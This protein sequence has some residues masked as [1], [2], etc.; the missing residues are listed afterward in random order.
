[1]RIQEKISQYEW[2]AV[3]LEGLQSELQPFLGQELSLPRE[4]GGWWHQYVCPKHHTELLFDPLENDAHAFYCTHG[5]EWSG[6]PYRGAWLVFKHQS[7]VRYALQSATVYAAAHDR[8]YAEL[9]KSILVRYAAQFPLYPVHPDAQPWMLSGRAFHQALT[10][11][12]WA[13]SL[14]RG[15]LL[16]CDEGIEFSSADQKVLDTFFHMLE[17]SMLQ[18][19]RVLVHE[20]KNPENNYTA[21][22]NAALSCICAV[23]GDKEKLLELV[24]GEGGL[25]H[26]LT[27]GIKPD[28]FEFEGTLYY[29]IFVLRAYLITA[30]MADRFAVDLYAVQGDQG[31][32][33]KGMF[34]VLVELANDQGELPALHDGPYKRLPFAREISEV[35]EIGLSKYKES[36]YL[37]LLANAYRQLNGEASRT[38]L[39]ALVFGT[40]EWELNKKK[41]NSTASILL[42]DSGFVILRHPQ[43]PLSVISDFGPHGGSHGHYDKLNI[44]LNHKSGKVSSELGMVPYGSDLR[45][46]WYAETASHNTVSVNGKSQLPHD[47]KCIRY[48]TNNKYTYAWLQSKDA[49]QGC[50]FDRHLMLT[51]DWLLDWFE[52][53]LE[54][55][56]TM[57]WWFHAQ[58]GLCTESPDR[59]LESQDILGGHDGYDKVQVISRMDG[60]QNMESCK[61]RLNIDSSIETPRDQNVGMTTL[62]YPASLIYR[63]NM[64]GPAVDPTQTIE[65]I[66]HRQTADKSRF[67]SAFRAGYEWA[68]L[69]SLGIQA[70]GEGIEIATEA[71]QKSV[72]LNHQGLKIL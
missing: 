57:D 67:I 17:E 9:S 36:S 29:H 68:E 51:E 64:P 33:F 20:R 60:K 54:R 71:A 66:M 47:G 28:Q 15:Y 8:E 12:I 4:P 32:S 31:Q 16:L 10:E 11:A 30:E 22:L 52:V 39:E 2:S 37:P 3:T 46:G 14:I 18:Y 19:R 38:G 5:C 24:N 27:I 69:R 6:E 49:Y 34:N 62:L 42:E 21:W 53:T 65:G 61:F 26:H 58:G 48:E 25:I 1:M 72:Y 40:G 50:T 63:V 55:E 7:L 59:W 43:N 13:T 35:L 56:Q 45:K 23:R 44:I 70:N 41:E